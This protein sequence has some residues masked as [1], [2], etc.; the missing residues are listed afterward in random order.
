MDALPKLLPG[1]LGQLGPSVAILVTLLVMAVTFL[2]LALRDANKQAL[3][4]IIAMT[5]AVERNTTALTMLREAMDARNRESADVR[6]TVL[7]LKETMD[8]AVEQGRDRYEEI[9]R[10]LEKRGG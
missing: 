6:M 3:A 8:R 4:N 10:A 5:Q 9:R 2:W 7:L 1:W